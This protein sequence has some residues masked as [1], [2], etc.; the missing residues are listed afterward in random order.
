MSAYTKNWRLSFNTKKTK[1]L[2]F[3]KA[4][5]VHEH[6]QWTYNGLKLDI[7]DQFCY[8]GVVF[9]Y[10]CKFL[11][12]QKHCAEQGRKA[13]YSMKR[14]VVPFYFNVC[15][16][17]SLFDTY[18]LSILM[19]GCEVWGMHKAPMIEKVHID[20]CKVLLGVKRSTTNV[21]VYYELGRLPLKYERNYRILKLWCKLINT[22]NCIMKACYKELVLNFTKFNNFSTYVKS[23]LY[24]LG[25]M[26][27][28]DNQWN[29]QNFISVYLIKQNK[30]RIHY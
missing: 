10:N 2:I 1:I 6:E 30:R 12:T 17:L 5:N 26:Y 28:W 20:F 15:T 16:M 3:R 14:N 7:V 4:G 9:N 29:L 22:D 11:V 23:L 24:N 13:L 27:V 25:K 8:L 18:V 21:M 19:Y